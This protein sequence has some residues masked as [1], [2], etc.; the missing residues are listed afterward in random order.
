MCRSW[1]ASCARWAG[2][3]DMDRG[4]MIYEVNRRMITAMIDDVVTKS[5]ARLARVGARSLDDVR[6]AGEAVVA[7]SDERR[8]GAEGVARRFC[9]GRSIGINA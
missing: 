1:A 7:F 3:G 2:C 6:H 4:R 9:S 5:R 8:G